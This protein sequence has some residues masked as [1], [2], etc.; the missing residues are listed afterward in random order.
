M[1][2]LNE[3]SIG[4]SLFLSITAVYGLFNLR[5]QIEHQNVSRKWK[6]KIQG[7][8]YV[9]KNLPEKNPDKLNEADLDEIRKFQTVAD[10]LNRVYENDDWRFQDTGLL[11]SHHMNGNRACREIQIYFNQQLAGVIN[12][13]CPDRNLKGRFDDIDISF[14]LF[15]A[16]LFNGSEVYGMA[17]S[18][19][20]IVDPPDLTQDQYEKIKNYV[21]SRM[22][23]V[24]WQVR[25]L[26]S[27]PQ[28]LNLM[29]SG[30]ATWY[31]HRIQNEPT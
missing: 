8:R 2:T 12:I 18:V 27:G 15:N 1:S 17:M 7:D 30:P 29:F 16:R 11:K 10:W 23:F 20:Q 3:V 24:V 9:I 26:E 13:I 5:N 22:L 25:E 14:N 28:N 6:K 4:I 21:I 19:S 31:R